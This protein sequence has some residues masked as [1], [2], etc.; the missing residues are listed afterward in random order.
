MNPKV[1]AVIEGYPD[2]IKTGIM[3]LRK[4][5]LDEA[6]SSVAIGAIEECLKWGEPA[7][8]TSASS[9]GSTI[10]IAWSPKSPK[11]YGI[12][13]NCNTTLVDSFRTLFPHHFNYEGNRAIFFAINDIIPEYELKQCIRM[14]LRY[15]LDKNNSNHKVY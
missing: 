9:S 14:A 10:R 1:K 6:A 7:F 2:T 11:Q 3:H 15:H 5:I 4:L 8:L 13:F 12:Y